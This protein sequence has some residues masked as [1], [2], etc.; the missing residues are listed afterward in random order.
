MGK[1]KIEFDKRPEWHEPMVCQKVVNAYNTEQTAIEFSV[2]VKVPLEESMEM[3]GVS[4]AM[5]KGAEEK[6]LELGKIDKEGNIL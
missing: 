4:Q 3:F 6:L 5:L 1:K 2:V